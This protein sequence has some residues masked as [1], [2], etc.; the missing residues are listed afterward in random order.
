MPQPDQP[1]I[2]D[3]INFITSLVGE[4]NRDTFIVG[5]SLGCQAVLRY[6]ET[7]GAAGKSVGK[8]VLVA[9]TFPI[10]RSTAEAVEAAH[11]N[12]ILLPWLS[13]GVDAARIKQAAG[14]CTVILSDKDPYI[15]VAAAAS[16]FRAALNPSIVFVPG[17]G[18]FNEDDQWT[19]L[20]EALAALLSTGGAS[21]APTPDESG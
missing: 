16:T 17:G 3:W 6:L 11:G 20:P 8:T 5:H 12:S 19:E 7:V 9:G 14:E 1:V 2:R 4:P 13:T 10:E 18:H 15:D 21:T